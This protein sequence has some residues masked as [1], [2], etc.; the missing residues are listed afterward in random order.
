MAAASA[1]SIKITAFDATKNAFGSVTKGLGKVGLN[2][3]KLGAAFATLG[4]AAGAAI[5]R[6]QMNTIDALGKRQD[7]DVKISN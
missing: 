4:V 6:S 2:V 3:A 5:V 1:T 7:G